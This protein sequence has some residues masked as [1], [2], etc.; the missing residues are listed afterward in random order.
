MKWMVVFAPHSALP[1]FIFVLRFSRESIYRFSYIRYTP[2]SY[3]DWIIMKSPDGLTC[4]G[5]GLS[6]SISLLNL[7][8]LAPCRGRWKFETRVQEGWKLDEADKA[9]VLESMETLVAEGGFLEMMMVEI[10]FLS[11]SK[12][13]RTLAR[14][15][16]KPSIVFHLV[17]IFLK[18]KSASFLSVFSIF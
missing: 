10:V 2:L 18:C 17:C 4:T 1:L 15:Y 8:I 12:I 9:L 11:L 16:M 7:D 3:T 6:R 14:I 5:T 13:L